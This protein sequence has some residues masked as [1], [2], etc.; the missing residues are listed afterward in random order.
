MG[1]KGLFFLGDRQV[2]L[3]SVDDPTPAHGEV[4]VE[5]KAS[6]MC[7]SDLHPYRAPHDSEIPLE[8]RFIGGHE[9]C[10]VVVEVGPGV[11]KHVAKP[12]DRVMVHH[13]HGCTT[14]AHCRTGW[15]QLCRPA[16]RTTYSANAHGAHAPYMKVPAST[17]V[18]LHESL[19]FEAGAAIAC[20]TGTA[21][22]ALERLKPG[23]N[24]TIAVFGQGPVGL[25]ATM[26]ATARGA[27]VIAIDLDDDRL[28]L[29]K[30]FGAAQTINANDVDVCEALRDLTSG[31][32]IEMVVETTGSSQAAQ[33]GIDSTAVWGKVCM[34]GIGSKVSIE[35]RALLDRQVTVMTSYTMS[36]VQQ[37]QCAEFIV[38]RNLDLDR[39]FTDR[40]RLDQA[41]QAYRVLDA[42]SSGKGVF[43][44]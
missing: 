12:G 22:G 14:C 11:P 28:A 1:V 43:L 33:A 6:G 19:S 3:A 40:W 44:F 30:S 18:C 25:S 21:W 4:V 26:L 29:A 37:Y 5:I 16:T 34:V 36:T 41:E 20:G 13:Y 23:G 31:H 27:R 15:P 39:L 32:G 42:Q 8:R 9:P 17:L 24:E 2:V 38:S 7:G 10:G 35:T